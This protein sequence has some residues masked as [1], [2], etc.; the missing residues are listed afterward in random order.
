MVA[1]VG[2]GRFFVF[3]AGILVLLV[4]G[5]KWLAA[6]VPAGRRRL[7]RAQPGL[8]IDVA[9]RARRPA[10]RPLARLQPMQVGEGRYLVFL[11]LMSFFWISFNQIFMTLPEYIRDYTDTSDLIGDPRPSP[12]PSPDSSQRSASTPASGRA[13][14]CSAARSSPST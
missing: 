4:M 14:C 12:A 6:A 7:A 13:P 9:L 2:N 3:V 10:G 5:S 8:D 1:V 11:L